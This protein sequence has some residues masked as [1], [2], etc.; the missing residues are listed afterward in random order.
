[1]HR[2]RGGESVE[3]LYGHE[4]ARLGGE[5]RL[6]PARAGT[7]VDGDL[8]AREEPGGAPPQVGLFKF[9]GQFP[10]GDAGLVVFDEGCFAPARFDG[11][12]EAT[13]EAVFKSQIVHFFVF[14]AFVLRRKISG[15][16]LRGQTCVSGGQF[17]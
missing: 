9:R 1:M 14:F 12:F 3:E 8:V 11:L 6:G 10:V 4:P 16:L 7:C 2:V 13:Q 17:K 5:E 15:M